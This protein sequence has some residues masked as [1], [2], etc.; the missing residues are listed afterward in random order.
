MCG[1]GIVFIVDVPWF[2]RQRDYFNFHKWRQVFLL[3]DLHVVVCSVRCNVNILTVLYFKEYGPHSSYPDN[4]HYSHINT[5]KS[6]SKVKIKKTKAY[7]A[8]NSTNNIDNST[9]PFMGY[10]FF[11]NVRS[12]NLLHHDSS[13]RMLLFL[14]Y[15]SHLCQNIFW[16]G[17]F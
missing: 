1:V 7:I 4:S 9:L 17:L 6:L 2:K 15:N 12:F 5:E 11:K 3:Q 10:W 8:H 14:S 13:D 16:V